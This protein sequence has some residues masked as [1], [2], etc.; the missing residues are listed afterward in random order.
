MKHFQRAEALPFFAGNPVSCTPMLTCAIAE[1]LARYRDA[2]GLFQAL[3]A[4]PIPSAF[5]AGGLLQRCGRPIV[6]IACSDCR[7]SAT[8]L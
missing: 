1:A 7:H 4:R 8:L 3:L 5:A 6:T 2:E